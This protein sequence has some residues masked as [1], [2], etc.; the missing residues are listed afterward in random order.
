MNWDRLNN[1]LTTFAL[2][3]IADQQVRLVA[4]SSH[5]QIN[6]LDEVANEGFVI[7]PFDTANSPS[8]F[9]APEL[10]WSGYAEDIEVFDFKLVEKEAIPTPKAAYEKTFQHI[11]E[12]LDSGQLDKVVQSRIKV[13]PK[14]KL[15]AVSI[16]K[17]LCERYPNAFVSLTH[18]EGVGT[19]L[20]ATPET[21]LSL[22][23]EQYHTVA[24][25]GTQ[26]VQENTQRY[27]W[28][29]K[30]QEEQ[31]YVS[32]FVRSILEHAKP[33]G[34]TI[35]E[36]PATTH[37]AGQVVHLMSEFS[38]NVHGYDWVKLVDQL[39]P[40][41]AVCGTPTTAARTHIQMHETHDRAFY[42]G[43][44]GPMSPEGCQLF[45]NLRCMEV[46]STDFLLYLGGG[47][48]KDSAVELEWNETEHKATTLLS[49]I[50]KLRKFAS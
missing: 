41:P 5:Q 11:M 3:R 34:L 42:T 13:V 26:K 38:G 17:A 29:I 15:Q 22:E 27:E 14:G 19:W 32:D 2:Y 37:Q 40:T 50:E 30:E 46:T 16:F 24:L 39:H 36:T 12:A 21:L 43:Y 47:I 31:A 1:D 18:L 10:G 8:Y 28:G 20:C 44:L 33:H 9:I 6:S 7:A 25:A 45:V 48:T 23:D 4:A 49:V 35:A